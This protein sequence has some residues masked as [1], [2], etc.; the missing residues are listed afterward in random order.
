MGDCV[1]LGEHRVVKILQRFNDG[2]YEVYEVTEDREEIS[3][4]LDES[5]IEGLI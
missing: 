1:S 3:W 4:I 5:M 2:T